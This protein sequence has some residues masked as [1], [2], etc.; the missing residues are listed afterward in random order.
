[1]ITDFIGSGGDYKKKLYA[2]KL[3]NL[4]DISVFLEK[5]WNW[6]KAQFQRWFYPMF[7][8]EFTHSL[9][10]LQLKNKRQYWD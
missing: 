9:D 2:N 1:M 6:L 5:Y 8:E 7:Y 10:K 3:E 4:N